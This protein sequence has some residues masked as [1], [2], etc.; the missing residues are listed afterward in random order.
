MELFVCAEPDNLVDVEQASTPS[1]VLP[2]VVEELAAINLNTLTPIDAMN[3]LFTLQKK[4]QEVVNH[5]A[6]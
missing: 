1:V 5:G 4:A 3:L 2:E 6:N